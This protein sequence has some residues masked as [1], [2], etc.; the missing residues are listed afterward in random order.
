MKMIKK[1]FEK[2]EN[3]LDKF[4]LMVYKQTKRLV[5]KLD[6]QCTKRDQLYKI[7]THIVT[8]QICILRNQLVFIKTFLRK[9][10]GIKIAFTR[11]EHGQYS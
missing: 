6:M 11:M 1:D 5:W 3:F 2:I 9:T 8:E 4:F 10:Y 7:D